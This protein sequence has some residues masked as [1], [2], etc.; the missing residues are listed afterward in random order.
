MNSLGMSFYIKEMNLYLNFVK[1]A[2]PFYHNE[3]GFFVSSS[4]YGSDSLL[5]RSR[6][7]E[8][9]DDIIA[10]I[11]NGKFEFKYQGCCKFGTTLYNYIRKKELF[12][13]LNHPKLGLI[14]DNK[15]EDKKYFDEV[16]IL[17]VKKDISNKIKEAFD[18]QNQ[19]YTPYATYKIGEQIVCYHHC[20]YEI[21]GLDYFNFKNTEDFFKVK[22]LVQNLIK[23]IKD[24]KYKMLKL[25][26]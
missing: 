6:I 1:G 26:D 8:F 5:S 15:E 17:E 20:R 25:L 4:E 24:G 7:K 10:N 18:T 23:D 14:K 13:K 22:R 11:K 16:L 2:Y 3:S 9:R 19:K 12:E 21:E